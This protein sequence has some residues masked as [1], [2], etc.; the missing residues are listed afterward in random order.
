[1]TPLELARRYMDIF[2][3]GEELDRLHEILAERLSFEGP[4]LRC[5]SAEDYIRALKQAPPRDCRYRILAAYENA[6]GACLFYQFSKPGLSLPMA[7]SFR[8]EHGKI[9]AIL[10]IFDASAFA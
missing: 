6:S 8:V 3:S 1:M 4:L 10:L 9:C 5:E 2:F 7:Q